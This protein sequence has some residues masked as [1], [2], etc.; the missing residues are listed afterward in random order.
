MHTCVCRATHIHTHVCTHKRVNTHTCIPHTHKITIYSKCYRCEPRV[1]GLKGGGFMQACFRVG[2]SRSRS[3][4]HFFLLGC[5]LIQNIFFF[6]MMHLMPFNTT[7]ILRWV[8]MFLYPDLFLCFIWK[9]ITWMYDGNKAGAR[10]RIS[11]KIF[12]NFIKFYTW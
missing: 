9:D 12:L 11:S 4:Q 3:R 6:L 10:T 1:S 7:K 2:K 5:Y 8:R